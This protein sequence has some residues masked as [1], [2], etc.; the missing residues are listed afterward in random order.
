MPTAPARAPHRCAWRAA[1]LALAGVAAGCRRSAL[2]SRGDAQAVVLVSADETVDASAGSAEAEPNDTRSNAQLITFGDSSPPSVL[3]RGAIARTDAKSPDTDMFR[4]DVPAAPSLAAGDAATLEHRRLRAVVEPTGGAGG[5]LALAVLD[6]QGAVVLS[7]TGAAGER[8]GVPNLSVGPGAT[9][10]VRLRSVAPGKG[11]PAAPAPLPYRLTLA[12]DSPEP[13]DEVEPNDKAALATE[14][15]GSGAV[16]EAAGVFGW[17]RDEDWFRLPLANQ[18]PG[19]LLTFEVEGVEGVTATLEIRDAVGT[20]LAT[21]HGSPGARL[22]LRN[23]A[24]TALAPPGATE[25]YAFAVVRADRG[26]NVDTRYA[27][28]VRTDVAE[29]GAEAEPNDDLAHAA[30][31]AEGETRAFL[32]N[33]DVDVFRFEAS[34]PL[35]LDV[36]AAPPDRVDLRL[37]LVRA[38]GVLLA[39]S[40]FGRRREPERIPNLRVP[41]GP[42]F[43]RVAAAKGDGNPDEP[44]VLK[45][46]SRTPDE[47][48]EQEPN[49]KREQA[50][51]LAMGGR[52]TG[53]AYPR[54]DVDFWSVEVP[55]DVHAAALRLEGVAVVTLQATLEDGQ[56]HEMGRIEVPANAPPGGK[57]IPLPEG[58]GRVFVRV[59][60]PGKPSA[61]G[62]GGNLRDRYVV[63]VSTP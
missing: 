23:L 14:L 36:S 43:V 61:A 53:L 48:A 51:A 49:D 29:P 46:M 34:A 5:A 57:V 12:L 37:E 44:Y 15:P 19:A 28:R 20:A 1:L 52:G 13:G 25:R 17:R 30:P 56:G 63:T 38:D 18:P 11:A 50:T 62:A 55:A 2:P 4:I 35:E 59:S 26:A 54:A 3:I 8:F 45:V 58:L 40:D 27:L 33:G 9:V 10:F 24:V 22:V 31:L 6:E 41:A 60:V 47:G 7:A 32:P 21:A 39:R 16:D 42:V